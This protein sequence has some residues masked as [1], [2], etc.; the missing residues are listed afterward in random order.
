MEPTQISSLVQNAIMAVREE[1]MCYFKG[2]CVERF[3]DT[4]GLS[5]RELP[6]SDNGNR[7]HNRRVAQARQGHVLMFNEK[8]LLSMEHNPDELTFHTSMNPDRKAIKKA[9]EAFAH[10]YLP[11]VVLKTGKAPEMRTGGYFSYEALLE[12]QRVRSMNQEEMMAGR[13]RMQQPLTDYNEVIQWQRA[14][15]IARSRP[16]MFFDEMPF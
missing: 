10:K 2:T 7:Y 9:V 5:L 14:D 15:T 8:P 12:N 6:I 11:G 3:A 13:Q 1:V 16:T 4:T